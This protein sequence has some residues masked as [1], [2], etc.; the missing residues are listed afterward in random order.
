MF[1]LGMSVA[2]VVQ[3]MSNW[4]CVLKFSVRLCMIS[5]KLGSTVHLHFYPQTITIIAGQTE[6][7][8]RSPIPAFAQASPLGVD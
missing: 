1:L 8:R 7:A 2:L 4:L 6:S 5:L 3:E